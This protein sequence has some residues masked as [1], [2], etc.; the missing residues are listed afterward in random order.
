MKFTARV[1]PFELIQL[2]PDR[3]SLTFGKQGAG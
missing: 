2:G 3:L 1:P